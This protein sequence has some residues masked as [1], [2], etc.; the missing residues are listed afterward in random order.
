MSTLKTELFRKSIHISGIITIPISIFVGIEIVASIIVGL[1]LLYLTSEILRLRGTK[2]KLVS[3]ITEFSVRD[4]LS[5][6]SKIVTEPFYLAAGVLASLLIFPEPVN[7][8]AIAVVTLGDGFSSLVGKK[9]GKHRIPRTKKSLEGTCAGITCAFA[10]S[11]LFVTPERAIIASV[12][13]M[14]VE[15]LPM[16]IN[17]NITVP[18]AAGVSILY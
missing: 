16:P 14:I 4:D 7:Y 15:F 9:Y 10:V 5:D 12:V 18:L 11:T 1:S 13:G 17:D 3:K 8:V 6:R 2:L